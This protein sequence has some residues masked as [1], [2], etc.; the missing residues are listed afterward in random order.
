MLHLVVGSLQFLE[1]VY[2][3]CKWYKRRF[4]H[5]HH[6]GLQLMCLGN[7]VAGLIYSLIVGGI[8]F[9]LFNHPICNLLIC[10]DSHGYHHT[11]CIN[12]CGTVIY[13]YGIIGCIII[14]LGLSLCYRYQFDI[15]PDSM[16]IYILGLW[17]PI[18][19][20]SGGSN[21]ILTVLWHAAFLM[22]IP[23]T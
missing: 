20:L 3:L 4:V 9:E 8:Y 7:W 11:T 16:Y 14:G 21:I 22:M 19:I 17:A 5:G 15:F 18:Y 6:Y 10:H 12:F 1:I 23:Y 2:S 13:T